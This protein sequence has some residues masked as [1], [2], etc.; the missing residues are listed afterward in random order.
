MCRSVTTITKII[1]DGFAPNF[2]RKFLGGKERPSSC[3]ITIGRGMW[4]Y[5]SKNSVN[6]RLFTKTCDC[7]QN[8]SVIKFGTSGPQ[9]SRCGKCCQVF[10]TKTLSR[11]SV[12]SQS[13]FHLVTCMKSNSFHVDRVLL[14]H[15]RIL[16]HVHVI[17]N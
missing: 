6:R 16:F 2:M 9:N 7:L 1:V 5:R 3:F 15:I 17:T 8:S 14:Q 10:A 13:T 4:K 11:L 12:L